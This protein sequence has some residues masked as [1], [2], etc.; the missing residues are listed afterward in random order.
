[1]RAALAHTFGTAGRRRE[2]F[3]LLNDL[4]K[5]AEQRY[6]APYFFA[7]IHIGLGEYD[8]AIEHL[9]KSYEELSTAYPSSYRP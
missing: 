8:R 6:V 3:Q 9:E 1:M 4:T 7:G 2:A 5:V